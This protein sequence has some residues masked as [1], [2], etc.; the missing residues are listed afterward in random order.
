MDCFLSS[1]HENTHIISGTSPYDELPVWPIRP[2]QSTPPH[3]QR[4]RPNAGQPHRLVM[5]LMPCRR[6]MKQTKASTARMMRR[7]SGD[8]SNTETGVTNMESYLG[9]IRLVL[10]ISAALVFVM[11]AARPAMAAAD[12]ATDPASS[13]WYDEPAEE[14]PQALPTGNGTERGIGVVRLDGQLESSGCG[15]ESPEDPPVAAGGQER[16]GR[17]A[18]Q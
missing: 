18:G 13:L 2:S 7:R 6:N 5:E 4:T 15:Q 9:S 12:G 8:R 1:T 17:G 16:R 10:A 3:Q 11:A 14:W